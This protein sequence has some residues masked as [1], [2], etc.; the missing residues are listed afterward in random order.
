MAGGTPLATAFIKIRPETSQFRQETE[1]QVTGDLDKVGAKAGQS[2]G[3]SLSKSLGEELR[4]SGAQVG[5]TVGDEF[6]KGF[7]DRVK[8]KTGDA[9]V[10]PSKP[11]ARKQGGESAGSFADGFRRRLEAAQKSFPSLNVGVAKDK[12]EQ[13]LRDLQGKLKDLSGKTIGVDVDTDAALREAKRLHDELTAVAKDSANIQVK[14]D[15]RAAAGQIAKLAADLKKID[16]KSAADIFGD[17]FNTEVTQKTRNVRVGP[18][19]AKSRQGGAE[20]GGSF[21]E[22]FRRKIEQAS[23]ALP[24][25]TVGVA[26]TAAEA[27]LRDLQAQLRELS[28]KTV[29]VDLDAG[30]ALAQVRDLQGQLSMLAATSPNIQVRA[31]AE[32]ARVRLAQITAEVDKLDGKNVNV[33]VNV[34]TDRANRN[35]SGLAGGLTSVLGRAFSGLGPVASKFFS[36]LSDGATK[37]G[38]QIT[39]AVVSAA[40]GEAALTAAT[41]GVDLAIQAVVGAFS[42]AGLAVVGFAVGMVALAP[43]VLAAG[44]A[45]GGFV[46]LLTGAAA[47]FAV[48]KFGL[49]G[50]GDAMAALKAK[51]TEASTSSQQLASAQNA[52]ANAAAGVKSALASQANTR[53]QVAEAAKRA[54]QQVAD[55]ERAVGQARQEAALQAKDAQQRVADAASR[56]RDAQRTLTDAERDALEVRKDLTR[57]QQDAKQNLEDL[58][59]AVKSNSL[60][61]RQA[62]LDVAEAQQN[63]Q[64]VLADPKSTAEQRQQAQLSYDRQVQQLDDLRTRGKRLADEQA[65]ANKKGVNGSDQ[66]VAARQRIADAD[67]KVADARRGVTS[68]QAEVVKAEQDAD[69]VRKSGQQR[70]K[71]AEQALANAR[72]AQA[73]QQRQGAFQLAQAQAGVA[74]AQRALAQAHQQAADGAGRQSAATRQ[75]AQAMAG[76]SPA[77]RDLVKTF[78]ALKGPFDRLKKFV[79]QRLLDGVAGQVKDLAKKWL[80]ALRDILGPLADKFNGVGDGLFAAFGRKDFI[81]NVKA[82]VAGFGDMVSRIG[83]SLPGVIDAFGRIARASTPVLKVLGDL[84]GGIFDK[85]SGWIR[86]ADKSGKLNSFMKDAAGSLK[87]IFD[88]A[89]LVFKIIGQLVV[90]FF[91][92]SKKASSGFLGGVQDVLNNILTWL[93]DPKNQQKIRGWVSDVA[94]FVKKVVTEWIPKIADWLKRA[95]SW[96]DTVSGWVRAIRDFG[97]RLVSAFEDAK[98]KI[99]APFAYIRDNIFTPLK[100]LIT[101]TLP[102]AFASG[103]DKIVARFREAKD[104]V[105]SAWTSIRDKVFTPLKSLIQDGVPAAFA[106]G[107]DKLAARFGEARD[108]VAGVW[109]SVRDNI[110]TPL[111]NAIVNGVPNAFATGRDKIAAKFA[112]MRSRISETWGRVRDNIF[113]PLKT[114]ITTGVPNAFKTGVDAVKRQWDKLINVAKSPVRFV[115]KTVLNGGLIAGY[116][117]VAGL[118]GVKTL[119]PITLPKGFKAGGVLES[120]RVLPGYTPGRDVHR[121]VS[122]TGGVLDLSGGEPVMRPEFGRAV[123]KGWVDSMNAAARSGGVAGVRRAMSGAYANGGIIGGGRG[124]GDGLGDLWDSIKK[125]ASDIIDGGKK[126][127]DILTDPIGTVKKLVGKLVALIPGQNQPWGKLVAALPKKLL[128]LSVDQLDKAGVNQLNG[129]D[130]GSAVAGAVTGPFGGSAGMMRVLHTAF[131]GL[132]LISGYRPGAV[133]LTGHRSWHAVN[134]AVDVPPIK[135]VAKWIHDRYG[136]ITKELITPWQQYNLYHGRPH[137]YTGAVWRQ[138]NFAGGNAHDHWAAK[139]GGV[140]PRLAGSLDRH[141]LPVF[142]AGGWLAPGANLVTNDTGDWEHLTRARPTPATSGTFEIHIHDS[143]IASQKH[144]EDLVVAGYTA[145]KRKRRL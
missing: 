60:D 96:I 145:A 83:K 28:G 123:G 81:D 23:K 93:S 103:K 126:T 46:T 108:R 97:S 50:I 136:R 122:P 18:A 72:A 13:S 119:D 61:Q 20:S 53:A 75:L 14:A 22:G 10:G 138:H 56:V 27:S 133:T 94:Q 110:F 112:E 106:A 118:F 104:R 24:P 2:L 86:S 134:R 139:L 67:Q 88:I 76:L 29:G 89:G 52:I 131:P 73:S 109:R 54:A 79:Q 107:R 144:A 47:G 48:F 42:A 44:G 113:S 87:Q 128:G 132:R 90:I 38:G 64:K 55:A 8:D 116:N 57:A 141:D 26:K 91:P 121:F 69:R 137:T 65:D 82:A 71:D 77:G 114:A 127:V 70:V 43:V 11:R 34:D 17:S 39:S 1:K 7:S 41:G 31:D 140:L 98:A 95:G 45:L 105:A 100:N 129:S 32:A 92:Q 117:K 142:D 6:A 5:E 37:A 80:P 35:V 78:E 135:A 58:A 124:S 130:F 51:Q 33:G 125:K 16:A 21:A 36:S 25:I 59:S 74:N 30:A 9:P 12:A 19:A 66:V 4:S 68:A 62:V 99:A 111:K 40:A 85:F 120:G 115:I 3:K 101:N 102:A 143:V 49:G 15:T 63:L 84:I